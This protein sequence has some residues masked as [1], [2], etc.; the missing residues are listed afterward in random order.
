[1]S[2]SF[3][4]KV[5]LEMRT[6]MLEG[7][8]VRLEPMTMEHLAQLKEVAYDA[9]IWRYMIT[10]VEDQDDLRRWISEALAV[11]PAGSAMPWVTVL[12]DGDRVIGSTRLYDIDM[13]HRTAVIGHTWISPEFRGAGINPEAKLLQLTYAF[14]TLGMNRVALKT[15]HENLQSQAAMRKIGATQ[16]GVFRNHFVMPDGST[17]HSVW[18]SIIREEWPRVKALLEARVQRPSEASHSG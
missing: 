14:E 6:P 1:M 3:C 18:F 8:R 15:H 12:K 9:S 16:E 17:R 13:R 10:R 11:E 7:V 4:E 2:V 5:S